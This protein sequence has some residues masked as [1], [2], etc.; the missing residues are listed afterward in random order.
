LDQQL[1][2]EPL[3]LLGCLRLEP[4]L[5]SNHSLSKLV[6]LHNLNHIPN[7]SKPAS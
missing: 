2:L 1:V 3:V 5:V 4:T 6:L 7:R